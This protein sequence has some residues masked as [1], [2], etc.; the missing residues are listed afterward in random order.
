MKVRKI[1]KIDFK[2]YKA[3]HDEFYS[4]K[5]NNK[6]DNLTLKDFEVDL[7][8][9]IILVA[10]N[11]K[12][13]VGFLLA[14]KNSSWNYIVLADLFV[15][16]EHRNKGVGSTLINKLLKIAMKNHISVKVYSHN[17][18]AKRLYESIGFIELPKN[19]QN[20]EKLPWWTHVYSIT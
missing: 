20:L 17:S 4:P 12:K 5:Y 11:T 10:E 14:I 7:K 6:Q 1:K 3:L 19:K 16:K 2:Q 15:V 18:D 13:I 9:N 8:K